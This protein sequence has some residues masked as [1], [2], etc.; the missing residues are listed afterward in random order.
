[1][2]LVVEVDVKAEIE[3]EGDLGYILRKSREL[4]DFGVKR[5]M[6]ILTSPRSVL[7][8]ESEKPAVILDW[9]DEVEVWD[10]VKVRLTDLL[11]RP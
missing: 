6:W 8:F 4:I 3:R 7:I 1:M 5:V 2:S 10:G 11:K 9:E